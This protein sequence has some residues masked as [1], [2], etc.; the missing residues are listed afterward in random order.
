MALIENDRAHTTLTQMLDPFAS[1]GAKQLD[2]A[3]LSVLAAS[4]FSFQVGDN[5]AQLSIST[6]S[7]RPRPRPPISQRIFDGRSGG[8][9]TVNSPTLL[10][11]LKQP[12]LWIAHLAQR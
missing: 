9:G 4:D 1:I 8:A 10:R 2:Q 12:C 5:P 6:L 7:G 3:P 11:D